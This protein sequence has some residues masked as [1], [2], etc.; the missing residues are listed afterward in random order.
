M[1]IGLHA[2]CPYACHI[3][4]KDEFFLDIFFKKYSNIKISLTSVQQGRTDGQDEASSH[5]FR[6]AKAPNKWKKTVIM[7]LL[8]LI[9]IT[10]ISS[11]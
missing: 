9:S 7:I 1:Y 3:F 5:F 4:V 2:E 10:F 8:K 6:L 11:V